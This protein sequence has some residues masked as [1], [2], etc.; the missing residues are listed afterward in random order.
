VLPKGTQ[1]VSAI[2]DTTL[3]F[4]DLREGTLVDTLTRSP[5][6]D[7]SKERNTVRRLAVTPDG[8][9]IVSAVGDGNLT[10]WDLPSGQ[11]RRTQEGHTG[12]V[13]TV[14]V[15]QDGRHAISGGQD[16]ALKVWDLASGKAV[17]TRT[18]P[19]SPEAAFDVRAVSVLSDGR[20]L[21]GHEDG[22]LVLW[23]VDAGA[24]V[25]RWPGENQSVRGVAVTEGGRLAIAASVDRKVKVLDLASGQ[26]VAVAYLEGS[27]CSMVF[28]QDKAVLL[29]GDRFGS[30]YCLHC[31][32]LDP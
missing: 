7:E 21:A 16:G 27:P 9:S 19:G 13:R 1:A 32:E 10:I 30:V 14:A 28:A 25:A 11:A 26:E 12:M 29:L 5:T 3:R 6:Q 17:A 31:M 4:W 15:T 23:D 22:S 24:V 2:E 18:L 8:R 20:V